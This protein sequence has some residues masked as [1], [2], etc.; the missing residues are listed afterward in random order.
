MNNLELTYKMTKL[1]IHIK[2][3]LTEWARI[4][5]EGKLNNFH[6]KNMIKNAYE[7]DKLL[8]EVGIDWVNDYEEN[9]KI[10]KSIGL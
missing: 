5:R 8:N 7:I 9:L 10:K 2:S 1:L 4:S 6:E 3:E